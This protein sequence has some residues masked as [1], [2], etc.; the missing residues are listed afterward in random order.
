MKSLLPENPR[1][2]TVSKNKLISGFN[3]VIGYRNM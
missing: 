2:R 3:K 1:E